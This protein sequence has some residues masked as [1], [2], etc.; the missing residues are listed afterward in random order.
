[1]RLRITQLL[2]SKSWLRRKP[3]ISISGNVNLRCLKSTY[4]KT[5]P[6]VEQ[7][8]KQMNAAAKSENPH[9]IWKLASDIKQRHP[10]VVPIEYYIALLKAMHTMGSKNTTVAINLYM[11]AVSQYKLALLVVPPVTLSQRRDLWYNL[12]RL[13]EFCYKNTDL[14]ALKLLKE[15]ET[16]SLEL[17]DRRFGRKYTYLYYS[18]YINT[19]L[20][21]NQIFE[22]LDTFHETV[23]TL[24]NDGINYAE[25]VVNLPTKRLVNFLHQNGAWDELYLL[26]DEVYQHKD[27][28]SM[29]D[30][31]NNWIN[32]LQG[33][34]MGN[35]YNLCKLLTEHYIMK[36]LGD[37]PLETVLF[38]NSKNLSN[39][40][41]GLVML[42]LQIL[43]LNGD[44][45]S[46]ISLIETFYL[47]K[48]MRG[49]RGLTKELS[50]DIIRAYCAFPVSN[51]STEEDTTMLAI[52][53]VINKF[54]LRF[55][56]IDIWLS[57]KDIGDLLSSKFFHYRLGL[58]LERSQQNP[59]KHLDGHLRGN[60]FANL[61]VLEK[62]VTDHVKYM[63]NQNFE[64]LT[65]VLF[66]NCVLNHVSIHQNFT[67]VIKVLSTLFQINNNQEIS[68]WLNPDLFQILL[69]SLGQ[70]S[71]SK[72]SSIV[73]YEYMKQHNLLK[74]IYLRD[75]ILSSVRLTHGQS[76]SWGSM[77]NLLFY[78]YD[79][80]SQVESVDMYVKDILEN[81]LGII[82]QESS[83]K[84]TISY[85]LQMEE[86][87][88][89]S[90]D[91][92]WINAGLLVN[93]KSVNSLAK[94]QGSS[95][96]HKKAI[97]IRDAKRL[98]R[99]LAT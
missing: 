93:L 11:E 21:C 75:F 31:D 65:V 19:F 9:R 74:P 62:F 23:D 88:M 8:G 38:E 26:L 45:M 42:I 22:A 56:K 17:F 28:A 69:H 25:I 77:P 82:K 72:F 41:D 50:T 36:D 49:E 2:T 78:I 60:P 81:L 7:F 67:G 13:F 57:Y 99:V 73:L 14:A 68:K 85:V 53:D 18:T 30:I 76:L 95:D 48:N 70:S 89:N 33:A 44:V 87:N 80:L 79:Y 29:L 39:I 97:D 51:D 40:C 83:L 10:S 43:S 96:S 6:T 12:L 3:A 46:T 55:G 58:V 1:M 64:N 5:I 37:V 91:E 32:L 34:V 59:N 66:I 47:H 63:L 35:H 4:S 20:N 71:T 84:E 98:R 61:Q 52:L 16:E 27:C 24:L 86:V 94:E 90:V 15:S 54:V 92:H